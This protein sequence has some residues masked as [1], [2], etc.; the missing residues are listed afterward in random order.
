MSR[1]NRWC[2]GPWPLLSSDSDSS[3]LRR[4]FLR[5]L[6]GLPVELRIR[7]VYHFRRGSTSVWPWSFARHPLGGERTGREIED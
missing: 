7:P 2:R 5:A 6:A 1:R 4:V 3:G